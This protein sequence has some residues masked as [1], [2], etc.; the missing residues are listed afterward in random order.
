MYVSSN[1]KPALRLFHFN[2]TVYVLCDQVLLLINKAEINNL[3]LN[4]GHGS[5]YEN[6]DKIRLNVRMPA[7]VWH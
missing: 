3:P 4:E 1:L 6:K 7:R 2:V 5:L